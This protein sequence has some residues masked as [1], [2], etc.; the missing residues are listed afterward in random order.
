[1]ESEQKN[2]RKREVSPD[3][4]SSHVIEGEYDGV[5]ENLESENKNEKQ[6]SPTEKPTIH[7]KRFVLPISY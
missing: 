5:I 2:R 3:Y 7:K 1:M 6:T 4:Y